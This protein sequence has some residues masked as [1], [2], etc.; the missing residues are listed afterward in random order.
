[1]TGQIKAI[2]TRYRGYRFRSRLEARWAVFFDA[3]GISWEYEPEGFELSD[4]SWYLP[5]FRLTD[6]G[7]FAEVKAPIKGQRDRGVLE[8]RAE[9]LRVFE[10]AVT[11]AHDSSTDVL[12]LAGLP[13]WSGCLIYQG[14]TRDDFAFSWIN[15]DSRDEEIQRARN[16]EVA[17]KSARFEHGD[18]HP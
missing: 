17:A 6:L 10:K 9:I 12:L 14:D 13:K 18:R 15:D 7:V 4:G 3:L 11:L 5:D 2:E 8:Q 16:A 1:M